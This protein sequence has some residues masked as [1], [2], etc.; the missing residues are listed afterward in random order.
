MGVALKSHMAT[1]AMSVRVIRDKPY[2]IIPAPDVVR[3]MQAGIRRYSL[4]R[5]PRFVFLSASLTSP[6]ST[7][8]DA[9]RKPCI[10]VLDLD[11]P[12]RLA[13]R[14]GRDGLLY[15][16]QLRGGLRVGGHNFAT[17]PAASIVPSPMSQIFH[18]EFN[19]ASILRTS[20]YLPSFADKTSERVTCTPFLI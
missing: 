20:I 8:S 12:L 10:R 16:R 19:S 17:F 4:R 2:R 13:L 3:A 14:S 6:V 7:L 15:L 1:V 11:Y 9:Q 18:S 5:V